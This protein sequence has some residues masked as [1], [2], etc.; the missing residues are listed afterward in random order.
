MNDFGIKYECKE[1]I[2]YLFDA[3]KTIYKI[4]EEQDGKLYCGLNLE[5]DY[6]KREVMVSMSKYVT[7]A[8]N[9]SQ[10]LI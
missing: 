9:K 3:I 10:H 6:Y 4:S 8:L 7:K 1:D 5:C 2:K